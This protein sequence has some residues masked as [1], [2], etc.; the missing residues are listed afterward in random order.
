MDLKFWEKN[1]D[2]AAVNTRGWVLQERL[3]APRVVH[4]CE[5]QIA[6]E[7]HEKDAAE[8]WPDGLPDFQ[9]RD[10][11]VVH[12]GR[13]KDLVLPVPEDFK[14]EENTLTSPVSNG[15][16]LNKWKI[17]NIKPDTY[18]P[19]K[20]VV[21]KYSRTNLTNATDKLIALSGIAQMMSKEFGTNNRYVAG[22]WSRGLVSQL[23]WRV[24]PIYEN[25]Q[26]F[27]RSSRPKYEESELRKYRAPSFSWA[28][29]DA[30]NGIRYANTTEEG[31]HITIKSEFIHVEPE[32]SDN[33]FGLLK[34]GAHI[35]VAGIMKK[36]ELKKLRENGQDRYGWQMN[37]NPT[38]NG[39]PL[40][41]RN[42]YLDAPADDEQA[43]G[44]LGSEGGIYC[45]PVRTDSGKY[46]ICLLLQ[47][48][49]D[50]SGKFRRV[51]L[52][53]VPP[54]ISGGH[55]SSEEIVLSRPEHGDELAD[56]PWDAESGGHTICIV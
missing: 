56:C 46:L 23:L 47:L 14:N 18:G 25:G 20:R 19:W 29:V 11:D 40:T 6:W 9:L 10:G 36:I 52:T 51:G 42:V 35:V 28:A 41:F 37:S 39:K 8:S 49:R 4:F 31:L 44:I 30:Q 53:K 54:Y 7:C 43:W 2:E 33:K 22:L 21:E 45:L 26:F 55:Q 38:V 3:L 32:S 17:T 48:L 34:E 5:K 13:L 12:G 1:V 15:K 16:G 50:G 24:D 27:Y